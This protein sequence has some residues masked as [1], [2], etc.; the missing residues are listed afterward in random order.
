MKPGDINAEG[1]EIEQDGD[2]QQIIWD[3]YEV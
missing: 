1:K 2:Y 3:S